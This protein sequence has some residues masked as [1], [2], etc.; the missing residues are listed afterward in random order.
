M[1][2][3]LIQPMGCPEDSIILTPVIRD[4]KEAYKDL[5]AINV[6]PLLFEIWET[7][8]YIDRTVTKENADVILS[9]RLEAIKDSNIVFIHAVDAFRRDLEETLGITI[10]KGKHCC[11]VYLNDKEK[12]IAYLNDLIP[13]TRFWIIHNGIRLP[14]A[15]WYQSRWQSIV[16]HFKDKLTFVQVGFNR[17]EKIPE[18]KN[19]INLVGKITHRQ[20]LSLVY[21]SAGIITYADYFVH[22]ATIEGRNDRIMQNR[23][24]VV[25]SGGR[26]SPLLHSYINHDNI[27]TCG[28]LPCCDNGGCWATDVKPVEGYKRTLCKFVCHKEDELV[29]LCMDM[30][31]VEKVINSIENYERGFA[32]Y[33]AIR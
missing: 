30:I 29:P 20:L 17:F 26:T 6:D 24:C 32:L 15:N 16:D 8:P 21:Q 13:D 3:I 10:P 1:K 25:L 28:K 23:P 22:L 7:N 31:S 11:E 4:L 5:Y 9:P 19:V 12:E 18:L 33:N 27:H 14:V 2:K